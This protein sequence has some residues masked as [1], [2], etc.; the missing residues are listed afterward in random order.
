M[1]EP[2]QVSHAVV[3]RLAQLRAAMGAAEAVAVAAVTAAG[4]AATAYENETRLLGVFL[5]LPAG[6]D[7]SVDFATGTVTVEQKGGEK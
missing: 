2:V 1:S 6:T 7:F 4:Q 5:G 3:L